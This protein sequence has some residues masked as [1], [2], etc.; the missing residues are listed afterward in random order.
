MRR[1]NFGTLEHLIKPIS[2]AVCRY[3]LSKIQLHTELSFFSKVLSAFAHEKFSLLKL[4][5]TTYEPFQKSCYSTYYIHC[6]RFFFEK[7]IHF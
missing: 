4:F 3:F 2:V 1:K 7:K 5:A 6:T